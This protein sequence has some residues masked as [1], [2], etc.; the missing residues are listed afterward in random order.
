MSRRAW[1]LFLALAILELVALGVVWRIRSVDEIDPQLN[2]PVELAS[3]ECEAR[4]LPT[5]NYQPS[6]P[7]DHRDLA[8][9]ENLGLPGHRVIALYPDSVATFVSGTETARFQRVES[10]SFDLQEVTNL[11]DDPDWLA[12]VEPGLFEA[13]A[14][15][16]QQPGSEL[17]ITQPG[18]RELRLLD[19]P[20]VMLFARGGK[21]TVD[22]VRITSW[23]SALEAFDPDPL[24]G[25][26]FMLFQDGSDALIENSEIIGLG[27]DRGLSYGLTFRGYTT[28]GV[29]RNSKLSW[30]YFG[31]FTWEADGTVIEGNLFELNDVYGIDP[32]DRSRNLVIRDNI[33]RCNGRHGIIIS[34]DVISTEITNN[35]TYANRLNGVMVDKRSHGAVVANNY[36]WGN[37]GDGI[38]VASSADVAVHDNRS[39][40]NRVGIRLSQVG[41]EEITLTDN[42]VRTNRIGL[43]AAAEVKAIQLQGN[44]WLDNTQLGL[45]LA[46]DGVT[47]IGDLVNGSDR[48]V[49]VRGDVELSAG[50]FRAES[51]GIVVRAGELTIE[52]SQVQAGEFGVRNDGSNNIE[53]RSSSIEASRALVGA[54]VIDSQTTT[55]DQFRLD[56]V[57]RLILIAGAVLTA[58]VVLAD[59]HRVTKGRAALGRGHR[60]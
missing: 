29:L 55:S 40:G 30:N 52:G 5:R 56:D 24:D 48:A 16:F 22:G 2:G 19:Q 57:V 25:R 60:T 1:R 42:D 58:S 59:V 43:E 54:A 14:G 35:E 3:A 41:T 21:V 34:E 12:E 7:D 10:G 6:T 33:S 47:S 32:H 26:P 13:G 36:S 49:D 28:T 37:L 31:L 15:I 53:V 51:D 39:Y 50:T 45:L 20:G 8:G 23:D 44:Q 4:P 27:S 46:S 18:V 9:G 11:V 38:V 17:E